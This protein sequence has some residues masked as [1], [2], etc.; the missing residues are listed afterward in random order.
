MDCTKEYNAMREIASTLRSWFEQGIPF[1]MATVTRTWSSSP[2]PP[3]AVM[4]A[5]ASS[6]VVG[7]ISGGC[8]EG[9][10]YE[11]AQ[12]VLITGLPKLQVYGV[13]DEEAYNVGLTCGGTIEVFIELV[14]ANTFPDFL[15]LLEQIDT[16]KPVSVATVLSPGT[17]HGRHLLICPDASVG[18]LGSGGLDSGAIRQGRG[19]LAADRTET[20][21]IG[22]NGELSDKGVTLFIA[23]FA[24]PPRMYVFGAIDFAGAMVRMGKFLGFHVTLCDARPIF[25]TPRR[26]PDAD[27]I[28]VRWP[29]EFLSEALIDNRTVICVLTHDAKFD[30]PLL[31]VALASPAGYVGAMGSRRMHELRTASLREIGVSQSHLD[32]LSSPIGLDLGACTPEETA[33]SIAAEIIASTGGGSG[34]PL[35]SMK[36]PIHPCTT[37]PTSSSAS[38]RQDHRFSAFSS[39][40]TGRPAAKDVR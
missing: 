14:D 39:S 6:E 35:R 28:V 38:S 10:V 40:R 19:L 30:V 13:A 1:A 27:D 8:V 15:F 5:T 25:A 29:H 22:A 33:V 31:Q 3:G 18:S 37:S 23:T 21:H 20:I 2:R 36:A 24:P 34:K 9:A 12:D 26:F 17:D 16:G 7:S 11:L 32:R 4:A